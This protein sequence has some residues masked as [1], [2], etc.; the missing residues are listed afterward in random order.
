MT[1]TTDIGKQEFFFSSD[2]VT[3]MTESQSYLI[4]RFVLVKRQENAM[5]STTLLSG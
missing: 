3:S 1:K 2:G 4:I 5:K